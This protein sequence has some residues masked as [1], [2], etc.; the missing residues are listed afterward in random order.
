M[1]VT[2]VSIVYVAKYSLWVCRLMFN[3]FLFVAF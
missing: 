1:F 3:T 2:D